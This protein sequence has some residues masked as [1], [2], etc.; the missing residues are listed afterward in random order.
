M[1]KDR[2]LTTSVHGDDFT[3]V[4]PRVELEW[5]EM[6]LEGMYER[7]KADAKARATMMPRRGERIA[8]K[9]EYTVGP[10]GRRD[11]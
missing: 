7:G 8:M 11:V 2:N 1:H 9:I 5:L 3:T 6:K 4:G 10:G